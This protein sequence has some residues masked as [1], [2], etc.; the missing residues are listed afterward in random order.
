M[1][2]HL[3][4]EC[5]FFSIPGFEASFTLNDSHDES[6]FVF[7]AKMACILSTLNGDFS[8]DQMYR[9]WTK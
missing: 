9:G 7:I 5:N 2:W 6:V 1:A 3:S 4:E 8:S